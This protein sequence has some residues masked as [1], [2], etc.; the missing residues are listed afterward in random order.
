MNYVGIDNHKKYRVL[1]AV[2]KEGQVLRTCRLDNRP[3]QF[4]DF[5]TSLDGPCK[6]VVETSR[7]RGLLYD[8]LEEIDCIEDVTLA[9]SLKV[10]AIAEAKMKTDKIVNEAF[11]S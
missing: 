2:N 9:H 7:T 1:T 6:T 11:P 10:R 4:H 5:L 8:M 3:E